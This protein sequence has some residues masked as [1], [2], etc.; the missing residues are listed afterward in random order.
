M[1]GEFEGKAVL[2][3]GASSGIG[4][5]TAIAFAEQGARVMVSGRNPE[6]TEAVRAKVAAAATGGEAQ[7]VAADLTDSTACDAL[8]EATLA[9]FGKLDVLVNNAG[10]A[11]SVTVPN[12]T[13]AQ[14]RETMAVNLD[15]IFYMSRAALRPMREA[16]KGAIVSVASDAAIVGVPDLAAYCAS[17]GGVALLT[18]AMAL[19]HAR[20]GIRVNAVCPN[21][22]ETPMLQDLYA[23]A[24]MTPQEGHDFFASENPLNMVGEPRDVAEAILY[25]ASERARFV[26]GAS[27]IIDGGY[28]AG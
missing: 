17:K 2:V 3:T 6:R 11:H 16:G 28:T 12:T 14:W 21:V 18:K 7:A 9:A 13:D 10:V 15:A 26:T 4:E 24:G 5:G 27:L 25:L 20:E 8:V 19:D 23:Q 1:S 22:I